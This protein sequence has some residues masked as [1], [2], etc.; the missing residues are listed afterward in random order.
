MAAQSISRICISSAP[1]AA[2][3]GLFLWADMLA[4]SLPLADALNEIGN[5]LCSVY[6]RAGTEL[7]GLGKAAFFD[8]VV[9]CGF[10]YRNKL[11]NLL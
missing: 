5:V 9:P 10:S 3:L 7:D 11:Q 4:R 6:C 1:C 2:T 8:S